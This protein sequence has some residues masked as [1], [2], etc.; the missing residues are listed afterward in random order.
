[1]GGEGGIIRREGVNDGE[2]YKGGGGDKCPALP[3]GSYLT[4]Y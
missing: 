2:N 1:M 4:K 3:S